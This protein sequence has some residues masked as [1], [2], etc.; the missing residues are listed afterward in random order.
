MT[1]TFDFNRDSGLPPIKEYIKATEICKKWL[2]THM[3]VF[4]DKGIRNFMINQPV[5][6]AR[7]LI[8]QTHNPSKASVIVALL[9]PAKS[10]ILG[11]NNERA[12]QARRVFGDATVDLILYM[13]GAPTDNN[14]IK[15]DATRLFMVEGLSTMNDQLIDRKRI[16]KHH[17]VRWNILR[18]LENNFAGI[19]GQN[20]QLDILFEQDLKKSRAALE[21]LDN[22]K[23]APKPKR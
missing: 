18:S 3:S 5:R 10:G 15:R 19:R 20:P 22:K 23:K 13:N 12:P 2:D 8:D 16:D 1:N 4:G 17:Q 21:A 11:K 7:L 9:G 14:L 6:A